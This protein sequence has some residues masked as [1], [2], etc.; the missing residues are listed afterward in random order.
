MCCGKIQT[1][2]LKLRRT[3]QKCLSLTNPTPNIASGEDLAPCP[4]DS[5]PDL[6][7]NS[8]CCFLHRSASLL[9]ALADAVA[10]R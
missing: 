7:V 1:S 9:R 5:L 6:V 3:L 2:L 8:C 4:A 10:D